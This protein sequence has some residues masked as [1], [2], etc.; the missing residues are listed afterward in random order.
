MTSH[1]V[2][3]GGGTSGQTET[4]EVI[5]TGGNTDDFLLKTGG[6]MSGTLN[7]G[8]NKIENI[9]APTEDT[10]V[11][12]KKYSD[13]ATNISS[14]TLHP[15]R[16]PAYLN[17][18]T[19]NEN[20][21]WFGKKG[22]TTGGYIKKATFSGMNY[23]QIDGFR[24]LLLQA[25]QESG[26]GHRDYMVL[27]D[28]AIYCSNKRLHGIKDPTDD[29]DVITRKFI[30]TGLNIDPALNDR[31]LKLRSHED[32]N[33]SLRYFNGDTTNGGSRVELSAGDKL[34]LSTFK[35][36]DGKPTLKPNTTNRDYT[37]TNSQWIELE[38]DK[39]NINNNRITNLAT[40]TDDNDA[41]SKKY[42]DDSVSKPL[43]IVNRF[44]GNDTE[45]NLSFS[46]N[47]NWKQITLSI[48]LYEDLVTLVVPRN[49]L[50]KDMRISRKGDGAPGASTYKYNYCATFKL[51]EAKD[52]SIKFKFF[53]VGF[54]TDDK[55]NA[56]EERNGRT[57][58]AIESFIFI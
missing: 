21:L 32:S 15:D 33:R 5:S 7:V 24:G 40:P 12:N 38:H 17:T 58:Y 54:T 41:A 4:T 3:I 26:V 49:P 27:R 35:G 22:D 57:S 29:S 46:G 16:I 36:K 18:I 42:I 2:D 9:A 25:K 23:L 50:N 47:N 52:T 19:M 20:I 31:T 51:L 13:N 28:G 37:G 55:P 43:L 11:V 44:I 39:V 1:A 30:R 48:R 56:Y 45:R 10:D 6:T 34:R 53:H 8:N 14:G